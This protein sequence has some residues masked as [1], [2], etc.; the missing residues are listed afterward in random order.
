[1]IRLI[2]RMQINHV[3]AFVCVLSLCS[4]NSTTFAFYMVR[5]LLMSPMK[6]EMTKLTWK[7]LHSLPGT[8]EVWTTGLANV[9]EEAGQ[10]LLPLAGVYWDSPVRQF[11]PLD[12]RRVGR[13]VSFF[14]LLCVQPKL[15]SG[16]V[17]TRV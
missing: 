16:K 9:E 2:P 11:L 8:T 3:L 5:A 13:T 4:G 6:E 15:C 1:M 10:V 14:Q 12:G 7:K 17:H